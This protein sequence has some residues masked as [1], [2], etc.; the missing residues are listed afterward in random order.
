MPVRLRI[1]LLFALLVFIILSIVCTGIYYFSYTAR[2]DTIK[3]RLTNR[4]IT[5][6]RLLSQKEIFSQRLVQRIDSLTTISLTNK[7]VQA[8]D[9]KNNKIYNYSDLPGDT[10][11]ISNDILDDTRFK[12]NIYFSVRNKE[13]IAFHYV[14][15]KSRIV[16]ISAGED[17]DGQETLSRLLKILVI[18]F[19]IGNIFVLAVGY[20]FS[21]GL[22]QPIR[23]ITD[24]VAEI[25]AQNL[26]RRIQT[27]QTK[28]EWYHLSHT[29]NDLLDRLQES[30]ELQ[31]R[32]ISNAS[33]ELST[34]LTSISSQ[35]EVS[36]Q[37]ER[38]AEDYKKVMQSIYQDVRHMSNLTQTLLEFAKASGN[39][40]GLEI[41]LV[42]MD[43]IILQLPAEIV[44]INNAYSIIL[45]FD[46]L[47]EDEENLLV[48]GNETLLL[49][50]IKNIVVNACK[51]SENH[52][53]TVHLKMQDQSILI[54]IEDQGAG[55][56]K[57]ELA[58][59]FQPFY[60][61]EEHR[62][63]GGFGLG[64]SLA[65]RIIKLHKGTIEVASEKGKGTTFYIS[66]PPARNLGS[67]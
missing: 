39:T 17:E 20:L 62:T 66:L 63:T 22:L 58:K 6:A 41:N 9:Y 12:G 14:D 33:H 4:A 56:P 67:I 45:Q 27:G 40:G 64:L 19:L 10:L 65:E 3:K 60:R 53:A 13:A 21:R 52:Q 57:E 36:L 24:D 38:V 23:K 48:F 1:T 51:Y 46:D 2:L 11:N 26:A 31:R 55:I 34:P 5:T 37:K 15:N 50:A 16:F 8:Y 44:K 54:I 30:F 18:S 43:E 35:L 29:L 25:S 47:P 28:D 32:F 61:V 7:T 42:R 59:I 49:T